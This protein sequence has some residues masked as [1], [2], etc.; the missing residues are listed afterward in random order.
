MKVGII[1]DRLNRPRTGIENYTYNLIK[2]FGKISDKE[3]IFLINYEDNNIFPNLNKIIVKNPLKNITK[4]SYY[5]WHLYLQFKLKKNNLNLD[6]IH[7]P[8]FM[9]L[10]HIYFQNHIHQ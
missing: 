2:G 3:K 5:F 8:L 9:I 10:Y 6:I 1:A 7:S 4:K